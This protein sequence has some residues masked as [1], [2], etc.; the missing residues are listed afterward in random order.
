MKILRIQGKPTIREADRLGVAA[1]LRDAELRVSERHG[2][3]VKST[4]F[5]TQFLKLISECRTG[6]ILTMN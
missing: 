5:I 4:H 1:S 3:L 6:M 2:Y